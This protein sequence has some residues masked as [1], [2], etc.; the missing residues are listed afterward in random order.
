M[1]MGPPQE[2]L[3]DP[4]ALC[5]DLEIEGHLGR[6]P[7]ALGL[8]ALDQPGVGAVALEQGRHQ[9]R[10]QGRLAHLVGPDDQVQAIGEAADPHRPVELAELVELQGAQLHGAAF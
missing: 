10:Q 6:G 2:L 8:E 5:V 9:R 4:V 1:G 3:L 7:M